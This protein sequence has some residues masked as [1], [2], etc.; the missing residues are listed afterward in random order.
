MSPPSISCG[1]ISLTVS[2]GT[3]KP[4]PLDWREEEAIWELT[5]ITRPSA[6]SSGPPELPGLIAA[7]VWSTPEIW[8]PLGAV[9]LAV[10]RRDDR[11]S[12]RCR[13]GRTGC[14]SRSRRRRGAAA[15]EEASSSGLVSAGTFSGSTSSTARSVDASLPTSFAG[16]ASPSSPKRTVNS[17]PP[18]TTCSLVTTWPWASIRKP[19]PLPAVAVLD[20]GDAR[21]GLGVDL[22]DAAVGGALRRRR[23]SCS[24]RGACVTTRSVRVE[25]AGDGEHGDTRPTDAAPRKVKKTLERRRWTGSC[26]PYKDGPANGGNSFLSR[27]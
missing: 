3:A 15:T 23:R 20:E 1:T 8:K 16:S 17:L 5:P 7:S 25:H 26:G 27:S 24:A 14:R 10:E 13:R 18:S 4:T 22:R 9:D 2:T 19:E 11:R 21:R 6:S 12:S